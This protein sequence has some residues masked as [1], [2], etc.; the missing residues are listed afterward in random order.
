MTILKW[1]HYTKTV[2]GRLNAEHYFPIVKNNEYFLTM[3]QEGMEAEAQDWALRVNDNG[4]SRG[5]E[6]EYEFVDQ[7]PIEWMV[8]KVE[9]LTTS[10]IYDTDY[11]NSLMA[12]LAP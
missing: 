2:Q 3:G 8:K 6:Y 4:S 5:F 11:K 1:C 9:K 7:P 10:I 12:I